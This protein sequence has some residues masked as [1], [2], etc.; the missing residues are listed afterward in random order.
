MTSHGRCKAC[1]NSTGFYSQAMQAWL[2][3]HPRCI[4]N[5]VAASIQKEKAKGKPKPGGN[6]KERRR[7]AAIK[8]RMSD[9]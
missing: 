1:G 7:I 5:P 9:A 4:A 2:C 6:R 3:D 8:R